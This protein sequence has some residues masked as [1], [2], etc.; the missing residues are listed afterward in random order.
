MPI[1]HVIKFGNELPM[2]ALAVI[3]GM[4]IRDEGSKATHDPQELQVLS[5]GNLRRRKLQ[6]SPDT[7]SDRMDINVIR[8]S[9]NNQGNYRDTQ[10]SAIEGLFK[11][12]TFCVH[13]IRLWLHPLGETQAIRKLRTHIE[14]PLSSLA[15][16]T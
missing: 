9:G 16:A 2:A 15:V 3:F 8:A 11:N 1:E 7:F 12:C 6:L 4:E 14:R 5:L 13:C 10:D